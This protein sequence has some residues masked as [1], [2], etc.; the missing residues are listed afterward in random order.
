MDYLKNYTEWWQGVLRE[1]SAKAAKMDAEQRLQHNKM[2]EDFGAEASAATDWV[3]ADWEQFKAR[4][5]QWTNEAQLKADEA[6]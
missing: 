1:E 6:I 4:V 3:E 5:Q 2:L